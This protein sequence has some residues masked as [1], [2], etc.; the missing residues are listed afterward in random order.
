[1][2]K[3][4]VISMVTLVALVA[5]AL[6]IP[7]ALTIR[8]D[9]RAQFVGG[10]ERDALATATIMASQPFVDWQATA[11]ATA[12]RTGARVVVV[13]RERTLVADSDESGVD[14]TFDRPE[15]SSALDGYLASDVRNSST[16]GTDLR[17][18]AAPIIQNY[19]VVAAVRL[20]LSEDQVDSV[21]FTATLWLI[22]FFASVA[23]V[24]V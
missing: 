8:A 15:I 10:L 14:R 5:L 21:V 20:S 6:A 7:F 9:Q 18:V 12:E 4:L 2:T 17:Y 13:D 23:T 3:R 1:M 19:S 24:W 16:L 11:D 22:A